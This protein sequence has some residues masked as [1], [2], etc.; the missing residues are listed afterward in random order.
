[1]RSS[2]TCYR[3]AAKNL[4]GQSAVNCY[5]YWYLV[6]VGREDSLSFAFDFQGDRSKLMKCH[7]SCKF[8]EEIACTI[9]NLRGYEKS[10]L[11]SD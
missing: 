10:V 8:P 5:H 6:R 4:V 3:K 2:E 1:M 11:N 9:V 7:E